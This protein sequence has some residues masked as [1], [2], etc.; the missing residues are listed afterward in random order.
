[1]STSWTNRRSVVRSRRRP[2]QRRSR[3]PQRSPRDRRGRTA[4]AAALTRRRE[5]H[6][7]SDETREARRAL[8]ES[9]DRRD[10]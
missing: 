9:L 1:M 7:M 6:V 3:G 10:A 8:Q 2:G 4:V 5:E